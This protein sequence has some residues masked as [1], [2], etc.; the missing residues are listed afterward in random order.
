MKTDTVNDIKNAISTLQSF[1]E[2]IFDYD[3]DEYVIWHLDE[4]IKHLKNAIL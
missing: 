1:R 4:A 2:D 3:Y